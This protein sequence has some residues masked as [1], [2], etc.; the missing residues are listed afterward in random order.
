MN[1]P[2]A[3]TRA[4]RELSLL[5]R[6]AFLRFSGAVAAAGLLPA[7]CSRA[8]AGAPLPA[9][10]TLRFLS[11]RS[12]VVLNA[13]TE[14]LVGPH[15]GALVRSG[16]L[17]PAREA[18]AFLADVPDLAGPL[19]QALGVLEFGIVPL[20][21]KLRPFTALEAAQRDAVL[22]NL[23]HSRL[24]LKRQLFNGVRSVALLGFYGAQDRRP[25]GG[26]LGTIPA[27]AT[28]EA[29]MAPELRG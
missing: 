4:A 21:P 9:D 23:L 15:G 28:I 8:P 13:A 6:R 22:A 29:A 11:P 2:Q 20:L 24:A 27:S 5:D 19:G 3:A 14:R 12:Y 17:D 25:A 1:A 18:E 10:L 26:G 16:A 7:G